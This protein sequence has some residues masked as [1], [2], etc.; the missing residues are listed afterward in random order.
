MFSASASVEVGTNLYLEINGFN[1]HVQVLIVTWLIIITILLITLVSTRVL[2]NAYLSVLYLE[3]Y[4]LRKKIFGFLIVFSH[5]LLGFLREIAQKQ[6]GVLLYTLD[7]VYWC[8]F[9]VYACIKLVRCF[10]T[11]E[12]NCFSGRRIKIPDN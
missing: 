2:F 4:I 6:I 5:S 1:V 11:L 8:S 12:I 10:N 3:T 7:F 9:F